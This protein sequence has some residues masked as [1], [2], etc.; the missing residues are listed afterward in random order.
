MCRKKKSLLKV[1]LCVP[2]RARKKIVW[3]RKMFHY[4]VMFSYHPFPQV[5]L[6]GGGDT[7]DW[8]MFIFVIL[9]IYG[10]GNV[11][12]VI[13]YLSST[14]TIL[15]SC[16]LWHNQRKVLVCIIWELRRERERVWVCVCILLFVP[17]KAY[18]SV[19]T[20][21]CTHTNVSYGY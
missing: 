3:Y 8:F 20:H 15:F 14:N 7:P 2:I 16:I 1:E 6:H 21:A 17:Y 13:V 19:L 12:L 18:H 5:T 9:A 4:C 10:S 11:S